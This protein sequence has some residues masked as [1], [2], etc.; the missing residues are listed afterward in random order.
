MALL[1]AGVAMAAAA[2]WYQSGQLADPAVADRPELLRWLVTRDL[3][4]ESAETCRT[5]ARRLEDEFCEGIDWDSVGSQLDQGHRKQLWKNIPVLLKPWFMDRVDGFHK[6]AASQRLVYVDQ[7]IDTI[8]VWSR[9]DSLFV[10]PGQAGQA[11]CGLLAVLLGQIETWAQDA[12]PKQRGQNGE[13][14]RAV[15]GR[16]LVRK[17]VGDL[18]RPE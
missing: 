18:P 2:R 1:A 7:T 10:E 17:V 9:M 4:S 6:C 11:D 12:D 5:L 3:R 15:Q 16:W 14:L 13:F 8:T